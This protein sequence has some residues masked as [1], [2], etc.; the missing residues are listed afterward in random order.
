MSRLFCSAKANTEK[1]KRSSPGRFILRATAEN[2]WRA[3]SDPFI[4][5]DFARVI[6]TEHI[7]ALPVCVHTVFSLFIAYL[8]TVLS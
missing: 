1:M 8:Q 3:R 6:G 5:S 7:R 2:D 4:L